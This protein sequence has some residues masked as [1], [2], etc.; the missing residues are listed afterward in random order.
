MT[1]RVLIVYDHVPDDAAPD[2]A[3][4]LVQ[5]RA[6]SNALETLG[7]E[8][9]TLGVTLDLEAARDAIA[10]LAPDLVF[11]LVES[12]GG[13]GRLIHALPALLD[14]MGVPYTGASAEAQFIT[15]HKPLAKKLLA[16][17]HIATPDFMTLDKL[18]QTLAMDTGERLAAKR[19][20]LKS[21]WEHASIGLDASSVID[22]N[23]VATILRE[24]EARLD[25]LG[26]AGFAEEYIDG[27]EFNISLLGRGEEVTPGVWMPQVLPPAEIAF[28][29]QSTWGS[30]PKIVNYDCKWNEHSFEYQH[31]ERIF[32]FSEDDGP[33]LERLTQIARACWVIFELRG[34]ARVDFRVDANGEPW[35]LEVNTNPCLSPDAGFAFALQRADVACSDAIGRIID[36]AMSRAGGTHAAARSP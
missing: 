3:D 30:R 31:T 29:E 28:R 2:Q 17:E 10:R 11:N 14:A 16:A 25:R 19:W 9:M 36:D 23:H 7:H 21:I 18:R 8:W 24:L 20:I 13:S 12:L 6:I 26:G 27:R 35:M 33:L 32:E 34:Y 4:A 15:S 22:T 1:M 5:A